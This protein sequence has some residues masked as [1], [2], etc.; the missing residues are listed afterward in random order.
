MPFTNLS[1]D[2]TQDYLADGMVED[3]VAA[4]ARFKSIY[5]I[6]AGGHLV[7]DGKLASPHDAARRCTFRAVSG[8]GSAT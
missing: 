2:P 6:A 4:L 3:I 7:L 5:V 8:P 1:S